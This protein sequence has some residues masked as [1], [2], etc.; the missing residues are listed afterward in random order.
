MNTTIAKLVSPRGISTYTSAG[1]LARTI[2]FLIPTAGAYRDQG[3]WGKTGPSEELT[4]HHGCVNSVEYAGERAV[5][6]QSSRNAQSGD[7]DELMR[8]LVSAIMG[9]L[10]NGQPACKRWREEQRIGLDTVVKFPMAYQNQDEERKAWDEVRKLHKFRL[11]Y[12]SLNPFHRNV[13]SLHE[14]ELFIHGSGIT[15]QCCVTTREEQRRYPRTASCWS[16]SSLTET[17]NP[18]WNPRRETF[19]AFLLRAV[20]HFQEIKPRRVK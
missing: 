18:K 17:A 1:E 19:A 5:H 14:P 6:W 13:T 3:R 12:G 8:L 11:K 9:A 16:V 10:C 4:N 2:Q 7:F 15:L 20:A